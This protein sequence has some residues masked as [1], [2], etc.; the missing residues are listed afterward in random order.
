MSESRASRGP[1]RTG[2]ARR[3]QIIASAAEVFAA[4]GYRS[5]SLRQIAHEVGVTPAALTR[6]F[7]DKEALLTAVLEYW[8]E[9]TDLLRDPDASGLEFFDGLRRLVRYHVDHPGYLEL[10]LTLSNE[11]TDPSHPAARFI[12]QRYDST[13][14]DFRAQLAAAVEAGELRRMDDTEIEHECRALIAYMDGIELQ[15]LLNPAIDLVR[16]FD[17]QL[18]VTLRRW[19]SGPRA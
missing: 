8:R 11:A 16:Q 3:R 2:V 1:Y 17:Q 14:A 5:G 10:F 18:A 9:Q 15:W 12:R 4:V 13:V 6:H 19:G 7:G